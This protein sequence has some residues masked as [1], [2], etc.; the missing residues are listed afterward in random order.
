MRR[1]YTAKQ[2]SELVEFVKVGGATVC[3]AAARLGV[4]S[5]TAYNWMRT[6]AVSVS[7]Q[8]ADIPRA[9]STRTVTAP[10][11][12]RVVA[13]GELGAEIVVR[14]GGAEIH[15]RREFDADLLCAVVEALRR[16][17]A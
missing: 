13:S 10:A 11:F 17:A 8:A 15:V 3:E 1:R 7:E 16:T 14:V 12:V 4:T 9:R 5:S 6:A 2:R